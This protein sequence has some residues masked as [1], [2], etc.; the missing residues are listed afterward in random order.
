MYL[1]TRV[2]SAVCR[3]ITY[4]QLAEAVG[5]D[6][7]PVLSHQDMLIRAS[8]SPPMGSTGNFWRVIAIHPA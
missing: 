3:I 1:I 7:T 4:E 8:E 5:T 6:K 2:T